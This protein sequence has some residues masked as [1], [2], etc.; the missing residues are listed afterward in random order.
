MTGIT[1]RKVLLVKV[2]GTYRTDAAPTVSAN[3]VLAEN[4]NWSVAGRGK[5]ERNPLTPSIGPS[6]PIHAGDLINITGDVEIKGSGTAGTAPEMSAVLQSLGLAITTV[7]STSNTYD[8]ASSA[9]KSVTAWLYEDGKVIKITGAR[10]TGSIALNVGQIPKVSFTL[11]GHLA[12]ESDLGL[13][14]PS[15]SSQLPVALVG[16]SNLLIDSIN[17]G[18]TAITLDIGNTIAM[19]EDITQSNGYGEITITGR[20][21]VLTIDFKD[22]LVASYDF[23]S[24]YRGNAPAA[25][26]TGLIGSAGNQFRLQAP[27]VYY[28]S[29]AP[30][31][32]NGLKT[33]QVT[34]VCDKGTGDQDFSLA[35]T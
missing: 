34:F 15:Y 16:M 19:P 13:P 27:A 7:A 10:A 25:F 32:H 24:K 6:A 26:D 29:M 14:S 22:Q 31:D 1:K 35:F 3:E 33:R 17:P 5:A 4:L 9:H 11:T 2:E 23:L 18:A 8:P 20:K 28:E 12:S 30:G 21:A